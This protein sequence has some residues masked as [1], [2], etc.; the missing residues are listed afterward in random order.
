MRTPQ[1]VVTA[2]F[3]YDD[4]SCADKVFRHLPKEVRGPI[5]AAWGIRGIKSALRDDDDRVKQVV[6]DSLVAGDIDAGTFED[7][8]TP[9]T[10]VR[11]VPLG[12]LWA[13]W[14][15]GKLTKI[16][17]HKAL[18]TAYE[19]YLF[20]ARWF[21]ETLQA[22]G[23]ALKG[24]DVLADGLTKE[25]LTHWIK[26][27]HETGD[28]TPKGLVAALGWTKIVEKTH[29]DV[30]LVVLDAMAMKVGLG[31]GAP[32]AKRGE[33]ASVVDVVPAKTLPANP[34]ETVDVVVDEEALGAERRALAEEETQDLTTAVQ[35][36]K[37]R[38]ELGRARGPASRS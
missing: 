12:E 23:G 22:K 38:A 14:R 1:E 25:E 29:N 11:W 24:T 9:D 37:G 8:L 30:L 36:V 4:K 19:L 34:E 33:P 7:G 27:V 5:L 26:R 20:D 15:G 32:A 18:S 17:I 21:L 31:A 28:G 35:Q 2:F 13:F 3:P 10:L 16:A 6:H